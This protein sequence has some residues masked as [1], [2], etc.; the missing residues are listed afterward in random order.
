MNHYKNEDEREHFLLNTMLIFWESLVGAWPQQ[1]IG[2][3]RR[4]TIRYPP[5][6]IAL[7]GRSGLHQ[8]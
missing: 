4:R 1:G 5:D 8:S 6:R 3:K 2:I 7:M